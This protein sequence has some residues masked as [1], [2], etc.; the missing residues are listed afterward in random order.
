[1][2]DVFGTERLQDLLPKVRDFVKTELIPLEANHQQRTF[3]ETAKLLVEKRKKIKSL[4][5]WGLHL[6]ANEGGLGL[7]LCEFG[8]L[9]ETLALA[10]FYGHYTFN[11]QAPDIGN[12]E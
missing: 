7:T 9:S 3:S 11:C 6:P 1:M 12:M 8:Q 5:L 10:P 2:E 4:G